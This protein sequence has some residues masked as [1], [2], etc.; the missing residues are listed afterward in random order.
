MPT[1]DKYMGY[2]GILIEVAKFFKTGKPPVS[3]EETIEVFTF[4]EACHESKR[5]G[6]TVVKL[7]DVLRGVKK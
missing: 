7:E 3:P 2:E 4:M 1:K 5:Q 6:G